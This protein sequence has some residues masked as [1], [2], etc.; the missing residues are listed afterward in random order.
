MLSKNLNRY[1]NNKIIND[2]NKIHIKRN[3]NNLIIHDIIVK[4]F[5]ENIE[6]HDQIKKIILKN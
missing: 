1:F 2:E 5:E 3:I 6:N 4:Y